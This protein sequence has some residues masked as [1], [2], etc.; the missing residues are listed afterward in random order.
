MRSLWAG[1]VWGGVLAV[2]VG[3][4]QP[5]A[6]LDIMRNSKTEKEIASGIRRGLSK[7]FGI[8]SA[9]EPSWIRNQQKS[10][11]TPTVPTKIT[12]AM[13]PTLA[14]QRHVKVLQQLAELLTHQK[15][16]AIGLKSYAVYLIPGLALLCGLLILRMQ[17]PFVSA[18]A[19]VVAAAIAGVGFWHICSTDTRAQY[20]IVIGPGLWLSLCGYAVIAAATFAS[21]L[22]A[23]FQDRLLQRFFKRSSLARAAAAPATAVESGRS[24]SL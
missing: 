2:V 11:T 22:P 21:V 12:G 5:W 14:N 3:F 9:K 15:Q 23:S 24:E 16:E 18:G 20:G 19:S 8:H 13:I 6:A 1:V 7:S 4:Y 17:S 10:K